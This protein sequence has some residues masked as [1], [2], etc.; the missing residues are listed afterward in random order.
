MSMRSRYAIEGILLAAGASRRFGSPKLLQPLAD[1]T[2][3]ALACARTLMGCVDQVIVVIHPQDKA[4]ARLLAGYDVRV[5]PCPQA[6]EG[7]GHS[8]ACGVRAS[9]DADAWIL[10]LADMPFIQKNTVLGVANLLRDGAVM[11][12]PS[13]AGRRGHPVG[14]SRPLRGALCDLAGDQGAR[15]IVTGHLRDLRLH[16]CADPGI[17]R[18]IDTPGDLGPL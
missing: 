3:M 5:L 6:P 15:S 10:A 2:P 11:A 9:L 1:G 7:M 13:Y 4:L 8:I 12:A 14:F 18:D 17:H 16:T